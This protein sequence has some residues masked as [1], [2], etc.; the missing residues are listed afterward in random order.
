MCYRTGNLTGA[1]ADAFVCVGDYKPVHSQAPWVGSGLAGL[2]WLGGLGHVQLIDR[3]VIAYM[4]STLPKQGSNIVQYSAMLIF[5]TSGAS[6]AVINWY[7]SLCRLAVIINH[8]IYARFAG[9]RAERAMDFIFL[10]DGPLWASVSGGAG[11]HVPTQGHFERAHFR[12][13]TAWF[14]KISSVHINI[15]GVE[16]FCLCPILL[17]NC[18]VSRPLKP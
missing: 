16:I 10:C 3:C 8:G 18:S 9:T 14:T 2:N 6:H 5:F 12:C 11:C 17:R 15:C 13:D 7:P 4:A 1:T